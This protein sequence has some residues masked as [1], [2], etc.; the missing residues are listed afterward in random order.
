MVARWCTAIQGLDCAM[1][2]VFGTQNKWADTL[3][4]VCPNIMEL[5]IANMLK[6]MDAPGLI[7]AAIED[8]RD[9]ILEQLECRAVTRL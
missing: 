6:I 7:V 1:N 2:F 9:V 5:S 4:R 3:R 8:Y